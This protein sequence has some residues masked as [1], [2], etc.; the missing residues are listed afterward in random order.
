MI[1]SKALISIATIHY[2]TRKFNFGVVQFL[3]FRVDLVLRF[4]FKK[5]KNVKFVIYVSLCF[6]MISTLSSIVFF[7]CL[8]SFILFTTFLTEHK[9]ER[10]KLNGLFDILTQNKRR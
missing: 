6:V 3:H 1:K 8:I 9:K 10:D 2:Q 4:F 7:F 5:K